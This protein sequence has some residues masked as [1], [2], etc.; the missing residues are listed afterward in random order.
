M[1]YHS[2]MA[3]RA[4]EAP[5]ASWVSVPGPAPTTRRVSLN[6][7]SSSTREVSSSPEGVI[8]LRRPWARLGA[9]TAPSSR[10]ENRYS[11]LAISLVTVDC[12]SAET[13]AAASKTTIK[14]VDLADFF[15]IPPN[16]YPYE[17]PS[18]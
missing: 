12:Q 11:D 2:R 8:V 16:S 17:Y 18:P 1:T 5:T 4:I 13:G 9:E 7:D 6:P 15:T 10:A 14:K 3:P